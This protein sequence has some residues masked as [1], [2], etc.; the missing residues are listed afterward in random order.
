MADEHAQYTLYGTNE[1]I[2]HY[3]SARTRCCEE[4]EIKKN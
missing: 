3:V 1:H 2:R 4:I